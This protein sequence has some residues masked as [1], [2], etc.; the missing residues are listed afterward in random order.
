MRDVDVPEVHDQQRR[1]QA[2]HDLFGHEERQLVTARGDRRVVEV[3]E[4]RLREALLQ[5]GAQR[6]ARLEDL[7]PEPFVALVERQHHALGERLPIFDAGPRLRADRGLDRLDQELLG[8]HDVRRVRVAERPQLAAAH[9]AEAL[10]GRDH[11]GLFGRKGVLLPEQLEDR[12]GDWCLAAVRVNLLAAARDERSGRVEVPGDAVVAGH[13]IDEALRNDL[14][15]EVRDVDPALRGERVLVAH[16]AAEGHDDHPALG[17]SGTRGPLREGAA[18]QPEIG[19]AR[20]EELQRV[21]P[22]QRNP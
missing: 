17:L 9:Q 7:P 3:V 8:E 10:V 1:R 13:R 15:G 6:A 2:V 21:A 19:Q 11:P 20:R 5:I 22:A 16:A 4:E 18:R 12:R 14:R